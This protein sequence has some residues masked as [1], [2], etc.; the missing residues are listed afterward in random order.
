MSLKAILDEVDKLEGEA[1]ASGNAVLQNIA[2]SIRAHVAAIAGEVATGATAVAAG[3]QTV[4]DDQ[5]NTTTQ[6]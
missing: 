5:A 1:T 6:G 3:A 4:A 2:A